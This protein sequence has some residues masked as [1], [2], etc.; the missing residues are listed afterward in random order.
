MKKKNPLY[1]KNNIVLQKSF[2]F[3]LGVIK[4]YKKLKKDNEFIISRQLLRSSSGIWANIMEAYYWSSRKDFLNKMYIS[5]KEANE[6]LYWLELLKN[7]KIIKWVDYSEHIE[8][9]NEIIAILSKITKT[10]KQN[11]T[12]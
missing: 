5:L 2:K 12:K 9:I 8:Q 4:V 10:T 1:D 7:S 11:L 6:T 3:S